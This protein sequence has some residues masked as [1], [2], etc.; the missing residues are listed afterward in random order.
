MTSRSILKQYPKIP[1]NLIFLL[2]LLILLSLSSPTECTNVKWIGNN[3]PN[4]PLASRVPR[5]QKYWDENNIERPDY[6]KT[7]AEIAAE[8]MNGNSGSSRSNS[9]SNRK[10]II[11]SII[12]GIFV[13][14]WIMIYRFGI[15]GKYQGGTRL[16]NS[17]ATNSSHNILNYA[18]K[19]KKTDTNNVESLEEKARKARL[20]R[21]ENQIHSSSKE[22]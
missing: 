6:A 9:N 5:S 1:T 8:K 3:N 14:L 7:D 13:S 16:G 20:A 17:S 21:F 4:S 11:R 22:D 15:M 19:M 18:M 2:S 12:G 10:V